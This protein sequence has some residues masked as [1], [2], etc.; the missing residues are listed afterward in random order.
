MIQRQ[1]M[2]PTTFF[3]ARFPEP[4]ALKQ[5]LLELCYRLKEREPPW[6]VAARSKQGLYESQPRLF[7]HAEASPLVAFCNVNGVNRFYSSNLFDP[8]EVADIVPEEGKLILF[9]GY[10]RHAALPYTG[11]LDRVVIS[12]NALLR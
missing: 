9:P 12:F 2:W 1:E 3:V 6:Q 11:K 5:P 8:N 4:G 10:V 7:E